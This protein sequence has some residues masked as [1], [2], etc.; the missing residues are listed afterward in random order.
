MVSDVQ[1]LTAIMSE[2]PRALEPSFLATHVWTSLL[3]PALI[4]LPTRDQ[5]LFD[6]VRMLATNTPTHVIIL[7]EALTLELQRFQM[8]DHWI[9][10]ALIQLPMET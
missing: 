10:Q 1:Q 3:L 4:Q 2:Y 6:A 9:R 5:S 7:L 8:E